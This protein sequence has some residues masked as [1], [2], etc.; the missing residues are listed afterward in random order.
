MDGSACLSVVAALGEQS[1]DRD[2]VRKLQDR[3]RRSRSD[4]PRTSIDQRRNFAVLTLRR[5]VIGVQQGGGLHRVTLDA[6]QRGC[7]R[8]RRKYDRRQH[9]NNREHADD[10]EKRES[11]RLSL[12][13]SSS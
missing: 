10:F 5:V 3:A 1:I 9:R 7:A 4:D 13:A 11:V 2:V 12:S 6:G 8:Q